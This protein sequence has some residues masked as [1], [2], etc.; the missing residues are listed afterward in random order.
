MR[1]DEL[2]KGLWGYKKD[3]VYHYIVSIEEKA[4]ERLAEKDARLEK[5]EAES[6]RQL[7]QME[8]ENKQQVREL[9][10]VA[11][12]LREENAALRDNQAVVFS[13]MLEAQKYAE[14]LKADSERQ[15][16]LAQEKFSADIR[17][18]NRQLE[19]HTGQIRQLR[20]MIWEM[21]KEFDGRLE[22]TERALNHLAACAPGTEPDPA[23]A[24]S[25]EAGDEPW[26]KISFT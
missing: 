24:A 11:Q 10:A 15:K 22:D 7:A 2:K 5:L 14:Q 6:K 16:Q 13:T 20:A 18:K 9:E 26:K 12:A 25:D 17:Q 23:P 19:E 21:L 8:N 3:S 1:M 4:S